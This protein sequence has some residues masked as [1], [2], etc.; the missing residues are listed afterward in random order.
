MCDKDPYP[1]LPLQRKQR[2]EQEEVVK[3][4]SLPASSRVRI[5]DPKTSKQQKVNFPA[6]P[7]YEPETP[8]TCQ[9]LRLRTGEPFVTR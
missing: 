5:K 4:S 7:K 2:P 9:T 1:R 6:T 8:K 3:K